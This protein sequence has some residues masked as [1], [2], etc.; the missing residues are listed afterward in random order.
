MAEVAI[1]ARRR[2]AERAVGSGVSGSVCVVGNVSGSVCVV[3][4][5]GGVT[6]FARREVEWRCVGGVVAKHV[7]GDGPC[8]VVPPL[9]VDVGVNMVHLHMS[10]A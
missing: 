8:D 6:G 9:C 2:V 3:G 4:V 10:R 1:S 5:S 7:V